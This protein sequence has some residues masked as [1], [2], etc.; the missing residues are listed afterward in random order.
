M[1]ET[2]ICRE[3]KKKTQGIHLGAH[4]VAAWWNKLNVHTKLQL[5]HYLGLFEFS[6]S[7]TLYSAF[8]VEKYL[9]H[10]K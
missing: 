4:R 5:C 6:D 10:R 9:D 2:L 8:S 7:S 1:K 3:K